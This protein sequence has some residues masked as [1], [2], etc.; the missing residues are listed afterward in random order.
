[1]D[2]QTGRPG[3]INGG[4]RTRTLRLGGF[5]LGRRRQAYG[6]W[7][8]GVLRSRRD[9]LDGR[10][11]NNTSG[12]NA[13]QRGQTRGEEDGRA[14]TNILAASPGPLLPS[15]EDILLGRVVEI[16]RHRRARGGH[17]RGRGGG[18]SARRREGGRRR[19]VRRGGREGRGGRVGIGARRVGETGIGC[20]QPG[21]HAG[22][23]RD[24]GG[25]YGWRLGGG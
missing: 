5:D 25:G 9:R 4:R 24:D 23:G 21:G 20:W 11:V 16:R 8:E 2:N 15:V 12:D 18:A 17:G 7:Q 13:H 3:W 19:R 22:G 6:F 1:M 10:S 14:G